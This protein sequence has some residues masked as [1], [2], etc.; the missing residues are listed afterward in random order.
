MPQCSEQK[1]TVEEDG[2]SEVSRESVLAHSGNDDVVFETTLHHVPAHKSLEVNRHISSFHLRS[3]QLVTSPS[4][5]VLKFGRLIGITEKQPDNSFEK[6]G[7]TKFD[8]IS[9]TMWVQTFI[10]PVINVAPGNMG[11]LLF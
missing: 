5:I 11:L 10:S 7:F 6:Y 2:R 1:K 4:P 9:M 8:L 3:T